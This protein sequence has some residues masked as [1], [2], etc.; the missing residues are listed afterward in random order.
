[1]QLSYLKRLAEFAEIL[2]CRLLRVFTGY[3][4]KELP[5]G[6]Q[7]NLCVDAVREASAIAA[8]YGV[9]LG[10]QNHH[11]IGVSAESYEDFLDDVGH[12]NC[13]AMFDAWSIAL[14]DADLYYWAKRL[15]PRM[16][17]TTVAD[18]VKH[19]RWH[20]IAET[21]NYERLPVD[22]LRAV[23]MGEGFIDYAAF[24]RG[25][26]ESGFDGYVSY[27]MC[28]PLR[29]GGS[30]VNLDGCAGKSLAAIQWLTAGE[31]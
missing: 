10:V 21:S 22:G 5:Y 23:P 20:L 27:E 1:M 6:S 19:P 24:F 7:W 18:Y 13:K 31:C 25:L 12:P 3:F 30:L 11:D 9:T 17:Q 26:R 2:G 15:A 16:V 29:G 28:W 14:Q 4:A 8:N